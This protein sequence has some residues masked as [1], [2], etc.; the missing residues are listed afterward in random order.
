M[1]R[2]FLASNRSILVFSTYSTYVEVIL[3]MSIIPLINIRFLCICRGY[4]KSGIFTPPLKCFLYTRRGYSRTHMYFKIRLLFSLHKQRLFLTLV[5]SIY[6]TPAFSTYVEVILSV[7]LMTIQSHI[8]SLLMQRL[9]YVTK[10]K[11]N[12]WNVFSAYA[13]VIRKSD[14]H[15][16]EVNQFSLRMQRLF[17]AVLSH[18]ILAIIFSV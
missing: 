12:S 15:A 2:L 6:C 3:G 17:L 1:Q 16:N 18:M 8:F 11:P 5:V 7:C 4:S 9:F 13:E 14:V 10:Y